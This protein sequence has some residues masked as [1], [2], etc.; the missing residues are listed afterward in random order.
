MQNKELKYSLVFSLYVPWLLSTAIAGNPVLSFWVAWAGSFFIFFQTWFSP[1]RFI[2]PDRPV[3]KQIMRPIFLQQLIFAGFMCCTSAFYFLDKMGYLYFDKVRD[4]DL[5]GDFETFS[6]IAFC[7]RLALLAHAALISGILII[8]NEHLKT[9]PEYIPVEPNAKGDW[10]I[11][12]C[13]ITFVLSVTMERIP[14]LYQFSIGLYNVAIFS[15][16]VILLRG[17]RENKPFLVLIGGGLFVANLINS[18]LTGYKEHIIVNFIILACLLYPYYKKTVT[19]VAIPVF[20]L[21]F[22]VLPTYA[23]V[24]RNQAWF[25][26]ASAEDA[27]TAAVDAVLN[28]DSETLKE[29]NWAFLTSRLSEIDMFK[30]FVRSTPTQIPY[31]GTEILENSVMVVIPRV[32]WPAKPITES[33]AMERVYNAGIVDLESSVS[34]KTRPVVDGYLSAGSLGVFIYMLILGMLSQKLCN[35]SENLF[36]GYETGCVIF[37]NGFFQLLWRGETTEF[38]VNSLFWSFIMMLIVF[39]LLKSANFLTKALQ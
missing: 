23:N 16:A 1:S 33:L 36:A 15:G 12:V 5:L 19:A 30:D 14:G 6:S 31:Y 2:L 32:L 11:R 29:N 3:H 35:K 13:I 17:L 21:L 22:Y 39:R 28:S 26:E 20:I 8:Q 24:L 27:R 9:R 7:Q 25:G 38:M 34:A 18:T 37:Y 4:V 10:I